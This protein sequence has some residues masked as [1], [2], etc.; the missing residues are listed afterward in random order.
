MK[1]AVSTHDVLRQRLLTRAGLF[2]A[3]GPR[4][5]LKELQASEWSVEFE[6]FMRNRLIMGALRYGRLGAA[7]KPK[8]DRMASIRA[9]LNAYEVSGNLELLIDVANLCVCEFVEGTHPLRHWNSTD[10]GEHVKT[11]S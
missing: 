6:R 1:K 9:R 10:D 7:G 2:H 5:S 3:P 8:Y 4:L 11:R